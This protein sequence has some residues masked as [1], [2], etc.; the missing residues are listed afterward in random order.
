MTLAPAGAEMIIGSMVKPAVCWA[1]VTTLL[2]GSSGLPVAS[3]KLAITWIC[4]PIS[5]AD[6]T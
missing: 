6:R 2:T 5:A 1:T 3:A 4:L